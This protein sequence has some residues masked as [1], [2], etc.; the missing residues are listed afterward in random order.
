MRCSCC[1]K[2]LSDYESTIKYKDGDY[3]DMCT[4]C[5]KDVEEEGV[6]FIK[7]GDLTNEETEIEYG[8]DEEQEDS[9]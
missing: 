6:E 9:L 2:N 5:L 3:A 4:R 7:R 8:Y 1:D